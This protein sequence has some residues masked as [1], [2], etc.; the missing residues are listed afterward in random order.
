MEN[1]R[2]FH[3][4]ATFN[5]EI[6]IQVNKQNKFITLTVEAGSSSRISIALLADHISRIYDNGSWRTIYYIE[7]DRSPA[8]NLST[9]D[10]REE[11]E[12]IMEKIN[13]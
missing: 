11:L 6:G 13:S 3:S 5:F 4:K 7:P 1:G 2:S 8:S 9:I 10:V 12:E